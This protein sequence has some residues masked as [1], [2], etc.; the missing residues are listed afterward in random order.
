MLKY[1]DQVLAR[2]ASSGLVIEKLPP[3]AM[4][5]LLQHWIRIYGL[6]S[7]E[8]FGHLWHILDDPEPMFEV[9]LNDLARLVGVP[10]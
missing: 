4:A 10:E 3:A 2:A 8:T 1:R 5:V 9:M 6:I 7:M